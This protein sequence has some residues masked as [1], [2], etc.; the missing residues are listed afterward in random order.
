MGKIWKLFAR[1]LKVTSRDALSLVIVVY[2]L[3]L[4]VIINL[5]APGIND[6]TVNLALMDTAPQDQVEYMKQVAKVEVFS[7]RESLEERVLR[8]DAMIGIVM[9]DGKETI[10][11]QGN[12]PEGSVEF[13]KSIV[14]LY[15]LDSKFED[16]NAV[17]HEF[18][19]TVP[20]MKKLYANILI[21]LT[22]VLG[23]MLITINI[24][25]E[26]ADNTI[27]AVQVTPVSSMQ[28]I[29]GKCILGLIIPIVGIIG[30]LFILGFGNVNM[31]QML[32]MIGTTMI[33]TIVVG[34]IEGIKNDD[35]MNAAAGIK[36]LFLP[37]IGAVL[38][39]ELLSDKW[40]FLFYW[41]PYYWAYKGNDAILS[42]TAEWT[43]ILLYGGIVVLLSS[44]VFAYLAPKIKSGLK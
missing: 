21:L 12:E 17:I 31:G 34:F 25:Q 6:T 28:Y 3:L 44:V 23:G 13:A 19:E 22:S 29:I 2:P 42:Y 30:S 7:S 9:E 1:D 20:P 4:A 11:T 37:I 5:I 18:G 41:I 38:A 26:K 14:S 24:V 40:Q 16:T 43:Q 33:L 36:M 10:L 15:Q 35:V 32:F 27:S 8:R 39:I